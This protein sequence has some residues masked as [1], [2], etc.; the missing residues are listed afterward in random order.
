MSDPFVPNIICFQTQ[1]QLPTLNNIRVLRKDVLIDL[2]ALNLIHAKPLS[3]HVA[4]T[5]VTVQAICQ[6]LISIFK[7]AFTV[8]TN[9]SSHPPLYYFIS[10]A[11]YLFIGLLICYSLYSYM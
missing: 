11:I 8:F 2:R 10:S 1:N 4:C 7:T 3:V 9:S 6:A 5:L